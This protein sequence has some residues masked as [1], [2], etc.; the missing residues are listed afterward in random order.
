MTVR[1]GRG[2]ISSVGDDLL[3]GHEHR[4]RRARD[5]GV[6]VR[7]AVDLGVAEAVGAVHVDQRDVRVERAGTG[8]ERLAR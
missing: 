7:V 5:V 3:G 1:S 4:L 8:D 2:A 6:H